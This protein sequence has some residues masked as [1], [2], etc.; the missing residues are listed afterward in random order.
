METRGLN[1]GE[2]VVVLNPQGFWV[3]AYEYVGPDEE[4][5][6]H[7]IVCERRQRSAHFRVRADLI[8]RPRL[9][10]GA[11]DA[12]PADQ[13]EE[14]AIAA[15][16]APEHTSEPFGRQRRDRRSRQPSGS[17]SITA[18]QRRHLFALAHGIGFDVDDLRALTPLGSISALTRVQAADLIDRLSGG[19]G[20]R[21]EGRGT[22]TAK[23]LGMIAHL[24]DTIG[25]SDAEFSAWV[26]KRF[27]VDGLDQVTDKDLASR[28]IGGLLK[29]R[30][31]RA[32]GRGQG[33]RRQHRASPAAAGAGG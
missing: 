11:D 33:H 14:A 23:Q 3:G 18:A 13:P 24:R 19:Q 4:F 25:F 22:A 31:K 32:E 1:P 9:T 15:P 5:P 12:A 20:L 28:I 26:E 17:D 6:G 21:P 29:M 16:S 27:H 10:S 8:S 2:I 30:E 7:A